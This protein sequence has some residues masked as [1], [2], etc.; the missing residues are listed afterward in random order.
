MRRV[1]RLLNV[2]LH[3]WPQKLGALVLATLIWMFVNVNDTSITQRSLLV[4]IT[5][6]GLQ[7]NSVT[8]GLPD[9]VEVT[10][11]GPSGQVDRL[12]PD[13]FQAVLD[14]EGQGGPFEEPITV[15]SPQ[16]VELRRV[17]PTDVIGTV[18]AVTEKTVPVDVVVVGDGPG[19]VKLVTAVEP[20]Q[21]TVRARAST[22]DRVARVLA[23]VRPSPGERS[24]TPYAVN[25]AGLPV[26]GVEIEPAQVQVGVVERPILVTR[27]VPV[28]LQT[29]SVPGF[30]VTAGLEQEQVRLIGPPGLVDSLESV[31]A[32]VTLQTEEPEAGGYTLPVTLELPEGVQAV[33]SIAANVRL[34]RPPVRPN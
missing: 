13:N 10:V 3:A 15:L 2:L 14:L 28:E 9:F 26:P 34:S 24:T 4:P 20:A 29:P 7:S 22:L 5:V 16:T 23:P 11:A 31:P 25:A 32:T 17:N 18:E 1:N 8:T 30:T 27:D 6:E 21:V 33:G 19:D 12:R